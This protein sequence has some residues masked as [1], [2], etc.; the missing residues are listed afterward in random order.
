MVSPARDGVAELVA[1]VVGVNESCW[2]FTPV[3]FI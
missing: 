1:I 2:D 3:L